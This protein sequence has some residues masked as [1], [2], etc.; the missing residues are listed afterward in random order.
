MPGK[1]IDRYD[2]VP[3]TKEDREYIA[4]VLRK[5]AN[6]ASGLGGACHSRFESV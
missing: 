6:I 1:L 2:H 4:L 5:L 3:E